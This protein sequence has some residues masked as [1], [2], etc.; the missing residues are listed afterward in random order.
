MLSRPLVS[1]I[2]TLAM[3]AAG[4]HSSTPANAAPV[5]YAFVATG[6]PN[7][8]T[9]LA[10]S[11]SGSF[12]HVATIAAPAEIYHLSV[13]SKFLFAIDAA[14]NVYTYAIGSTGALKLV[15][16]TNA[17]KYVPG[18]AKEYSIPLTQVDAAGVTIYTMV[19]TSWTTWYLESFKIESNG[20]LQFLGKSPAE[21]DALSQIRFVQNGQYALANGCYNTAA[22]ASFVTDSDDINTLATYKHE[23][24]GFLTY[25]AT[26]Q[27]TPAAQSP[28]QYCGGLNASDSSNHVVVGFSIFNPPGDDM[29]PG[30]AL[31]T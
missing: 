27:D 23:S 28:Y 1:L 26:S 30:T 20:E 14:S 22:G 10:V 15:A 8:I 31:G 19:G 6:I 13:T 25:T 18:F 5:A 21:A 12:T 29:E 9:T 3:V 17:G 4:A 2:A 16:T 11:S 24:N 7:S